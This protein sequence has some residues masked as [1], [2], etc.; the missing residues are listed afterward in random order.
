MEG[1]AAM[2]LKLRICDLYPDLMNLYGDRGN[3]LVLSR[4]CLWHGLQVEVQRVGL[5]ERVDFAAF[6]LIAIGGGQDR[7]QLRICRDFEEVKGSSLHDA[8]ADGV[9]LLAVCGGYQLM[10]RYYRTPAGEELPG[11]GIFDLWTEPG[12]GRLIGN[13]VIKSELLGGRTVVGF[14][15]HGGR[16]YLGE[17]VQPLGRVLVGHGNNGQDRTEGAVVH[18]SIGTYLHGSVLP[19]NPWLADHLITRALLRRYG[20]APLQALDDTLEEQAHRAA[21]E[22]FFG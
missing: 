19:K 9:A 17:G 3:V 21:V 4:R 15:N 6:D 5:G 11:L 2:A 16:T 22:R 18:N 8:V 10:G 7:D 1:E 20:T 14:E 13:V 12:W